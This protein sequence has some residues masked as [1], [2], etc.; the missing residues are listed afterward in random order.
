M[1]NAWKDP[2][3]HDESG[4]PLFDIYEIYNKAKKNPIRG[5]ILTIDNE[6]VNITISIN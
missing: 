6:K 3:Y 5:E 2:V 1:Q 4:K